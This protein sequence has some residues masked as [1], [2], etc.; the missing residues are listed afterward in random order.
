[1]V[2]HDDL[3]VVIDFPGQQA[4]VFLIVL[5]I[6]AAL[7]ALFTVALDAAPCLLRCLRLGIA[8]SAAS[9]ARQR[10][11]LVQVGIEPAFKGVLCAAHAARVQILGQAVCGQGC[12]LSADRRCHNALAPAGDELFLLTVHELRNHRAVRQQ[13]IQNTLRDTDHVKAPP[14]LFQERGIDSAAEAE[15]NIL[16]FQPA[17]L[18]PEGL[19][20]QKAGGTAQE[21]L[22]VLLLAEHGDGIGLLLKLARQEER[23]EPGAENRRGLFLFGAED[24]AQPALL[25]AAGHGGFDLADGNAVAALRQAAFLF[26]GCF[27]ARRDN[28]RERRRFLIQLQRFL[29]IPGR[30]R[31]EHRAHIQLQRAGG[32]AEGGFFID[33]ARHHALHLFLGDLVYLID[34]C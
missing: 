2:A 30:G 17:Q 19:V 6:G 7:H 9:D 13:G 24:A 12:F 8:V 21:V 15:L 22:R 29:E 25:P 11:C 18:Q 1:M 28:Q 4:G 27:T 31:F 20:I 23:E 14:F 3:G 33:A 16:P 34:V 10:L 32:A 26:T 5:Q